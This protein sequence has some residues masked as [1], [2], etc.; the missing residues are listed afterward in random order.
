MALHVPPVRAMHT[1]RIKTL[2]KKMLDSSIDTDTRK[3]RGIS[4]LPLPS[5]FIALSFFPLSVRLEEG[6][7]DLR[8]MG[9]PIA[10]GEEA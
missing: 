1:K 2:P 6:V 5:I 7:Q 10:V 8:S 9:F 3:D 4:P